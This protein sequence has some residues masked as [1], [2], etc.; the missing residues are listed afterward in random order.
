MLI[1]YFSREYIIKSILCAVGVFII[2]LGVGIMRFADLGLDPFMCLINGLNITIS[3]LFSINFG[4]TFLL[5]TCLMTAFILI[6]NRSYIGLGTVLAMF[7]SGYV[8]DFGLFLCNLF[9]PQG[10]LFFRISIMLFG[11]ILISIGSG[12]YFNT[13]IGVSPYDASGLIISEKSGNPKLYRFIRIGT[14]IICVIAGFFMGNRPGVGT[15]IMAFFTG[16]LFYL[17]RIVFLT[18]GKKVKIITW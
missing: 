14:D 3:K 9:L 6:F 16:P 4:T 7:L 17:F 10:T 11:I 18:W 1:K 2:G 15:I 8:S 12:I 5:F 13:H